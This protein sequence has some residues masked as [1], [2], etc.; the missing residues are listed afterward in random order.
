M[1]H[2]HKQQKGFT[3]IELLI[4]TA[5]F[6]LVLI[7]FLTALIR[8]SQ[9]FYKGVTLSNTQEATRNVIQTISDDLQFFNVPPNVHSDYFCIGDHRYSFNK[10]VQVG[11]GDPND[12]GII[13]EISSV[14]KAWQLPTPPVS[15]PPPIQSPDLAK[16]EKL[17]DPGMQLNDLVI[18]EI[19]GGVQV[20]ILVVYYGSDKGVFESNTAGYI[21][22]PND[23]N[24][25]TQGA[26]KAPDAQCTGLSLSSQ[27]CATAE[28]QTTILQ[29]F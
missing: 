17:L 29:K 18:K 3:V 27:F 19:N 8:I 11:S 14:C 5:V 4:A 15:P 24:Y 7:I 6:S 22:D 10:N 12:F 23:P 9:L 28:Y 16:A 21:N 1:K 13:R 2:R 26:Y 25:N 20:K